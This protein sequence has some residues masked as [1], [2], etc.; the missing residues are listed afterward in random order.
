[1]CW[2]FCAVFWF[3][4][5]SAREAWHPDLIR[6]HPLKTLQVLWQLHV[7]GQPS[8]FVRRIVPLVFFLNIHPDLKFQMPPLLFL[9][10]AFCSTFEALREKQCYRT[11][12]SADRAR[13]FEKPSLYFY[14][15]VEYYLKACRLCINPRYLGFLILQ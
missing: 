10:F 1:M 3:L 8:V 5:S 9:Q 12:L 4:F 6:A 2:V 14:L 11:L 13:S 15:L 7:R